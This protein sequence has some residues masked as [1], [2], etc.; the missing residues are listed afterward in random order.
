LPASSP[1]ATRLRTLVTTNWPIKV[2]AL[3]LSAVL[4]AAVAAREPTTQ[5]VPVDIVVQPPPGRTVIGPIPQVQAMYAGT[6]RELLKLFSSPPVARKVIPD[7]LTGTEY[8]IELS[9]ED[10]AIAGNIAARP[11]EIQPRRIVIALDKVTRRTVPV[12][13]RITVIPDSGYTLTGGVAVA[14]S[15]VTIRGPE[16]IVRTIGSVPTMPMRL[17]GV[18]TS[19]R[20][21]VPLDTDALGVARVSPTE[22]E[23]SANV[24]FI[25]ERVLMGVPV[26][27]VGDRAADWVVAPL[28][29]IVTIRGSGPRLV[30]FTRDS[31]SVLAV[32]TPGVEGA[33]TV[34]VQVAAPAGITAV[35]TPDTVVLTKRIGG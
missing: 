19:V 9:T 11:Q 4:W 7:T 34:V 24:A 8:T 17:T 31:V 22:V 12:R 2:T 5:R 15:T 18:T 14:P 16:N 27:V 35:A 13:P 10:L 20:R 23:V 1:I 33:D 30:R 21:T 29:V 28:A 25:S 3:V 32:P 6:T 26:L